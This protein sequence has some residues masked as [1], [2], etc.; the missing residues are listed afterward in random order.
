LSFALLTI[1]PARA[2][3]DPP[4]PLDVFAMP[5]KDVHERM[6]ADFSNATLALGQVIERLEAL[7]TS[8]REALQQAAQ[9]ILKDCPYQQA[10]M[11]VLTVFRESLGEL[12]GLPLPG[13]PGNDASLRTLARAQTEQLAVLCE[14]LDRHRELCELLAAAAKPAAGECCASEECCQEGQ[15]AA[16]CQKDPIAEVV[17]LLGTV[18]ARVDALPQATR[19]QLARDNETVMR[20]TAGLW[21]AK[22]LLIVG[23]EHLAEV[24]ASAQ[25]SHR[26]ADQ[27]AR[28]GDRVA[29]A[30]ASRAA[31]INAKIARLQ[32]VLTQ[33]MT[34]GC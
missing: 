25:K 33:F 11:R 16:C 21:D 5:A 17:A 31:A 32:D 29:P 9:R 15:A 2:Q 30:Y 22:F 8:E 27:A 13:A 26:L 34:L 18:R 7:P 3:D 24:A 14:A 1:A 20:G 4:A 12:R 23:G 19:D 6:R 28:D 10:M